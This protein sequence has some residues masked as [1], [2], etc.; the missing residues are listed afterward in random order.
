MNLILGSD[1]SSHSLRLLAIYLP[2][3]YCLDCTALLPLDEWMSLSL[4]SPLK[5]TTSAVALSTNSSSDKQH[6]TVMRD[7]N[8]W[9]I[10]P[11]PSRFWWHGKHLRS[12]D[13]K[14]KEI[15]GGSHTSFHIPPSLCSVIL[16]C[17]IMALL[18]A[19][20]FSK[21]RSISSGSVFTS[22]LNPILDLCCSPRT[23]KGALNRHNLLSMG[24]VEWSYSIGAHR[25]SVHTHR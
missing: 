10:A 21:G 7:G 23:D 3:T 8:H 11:P 25:W 18:I 14:I 13:V 9:G 19:S 20:R 24:D 17:S 15:E 22:L 2:N 12:L 16:P 1:E 5:R 6:T 4:L